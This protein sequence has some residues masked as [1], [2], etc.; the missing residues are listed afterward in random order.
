MSSPD[1]PRAYAEAVLRKLG[2]REQVPDV[3]EIARRLSLDVE[4]EDLEGF[5]GCLVR[6]VGVPIGIIGV[7]R[8][9]R[10]V[11]RKRFTVAH[12]IGHF[13][14]PGH[15]QAEGVC[16][17][18][19]LNRWSPAKHDYEQEANQFAAELLIPTE[20]AQRIIAGFTPSLDAVKETAN[21]FG[22]S[23]SATG[24]RYCELTTARCA[25]VWSADGRIV[26][27]KT[28]SSFGYPLYSRT[29]VGD[30]TGAFELFQGSSV[31]A[32]PLRVCADLWLPA[33]RVASS[34]TVL[35][36]SM[37]LTNYNAVVS[38][39]WIDDEIDRDETPELLDELDPEEFTINRRKWPGKR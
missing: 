35:E 20:F 15:D 11:A 23:L 24:W 26:W 4:E 6:P 32:D 17:S 34:A 28:S 33:G 12:E 30:G 9:I 25:F 39:I 14:L 10:E 7:R 3:E 16:T 13:L 2:F 37:R 38:F 1:L 22:T 31:S 18:R 29:E 5:D 36:Q 27:S 19:D 21:K 8:D